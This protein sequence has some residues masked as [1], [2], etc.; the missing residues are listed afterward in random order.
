MTTAILGQP[1][2]KKEPVTVE[3]LEAI[4]FDDAQQS[5]SLSDLRLATACLLRFARFLRFNELVNLKPSNLVIQGDMLKMRI[6]HSKTDQVR[7][8]DKI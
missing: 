6:E 7:K 8:G 5:G 2:I 4:V 3:M 1:V